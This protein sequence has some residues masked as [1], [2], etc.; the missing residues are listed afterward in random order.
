LISAHAGC[1]SWVPVTLDLY[2][3]AVCFIFR[4]YHTQ[5]IFFCWA[6][7]TVGTWLSI[8]E[9]I[10]GTQYFCSATT[11]GVICSASLW[12]CEHVVTELL[13]KHK[14][15]PY[16]VHFP[17]SFGLWVTCVRPINLFLLDG[18]VQKSSV[19]HCGTL[20]VRYLEIW[21]AGN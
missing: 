8:L 19:S 9:Y 4:P 14:Q 3:T 17:S 12:L 18:G 20:R 5:S 15:E 13:R 11:V 7:G 6:A 2:A 10:T 21:S 1:Q 16:D